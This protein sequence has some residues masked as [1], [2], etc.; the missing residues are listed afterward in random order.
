M[1]VPLELQQ[2]LG[3]FPL[4]PLPQLLE[5]LFKPLFGV[6]LGAFGGLGVAPE[7]VMV[8][9]LVGPL[10]PQEGGVTRGVER[11]VRDHRF[12]QRLL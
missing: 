8:V 2:E 6:S 11:Q 10:R 4:L 3:L 5:L 9:D 12:R 7:L 1:L